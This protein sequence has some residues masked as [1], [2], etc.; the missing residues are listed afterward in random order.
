[1]LGTNVGSTDMVRYAQQEGITVSVA[2]NLGDESGAKSIADRAV[3][4]STADVEGLIEYGREHGVDAV[5]AGVSEFN[6][7]NALSVSEALG[8]KF[9]C[10]SEQWDAFMDKA[11]FRGL[12]EKYGVPTPATYVDGSQRLG[13]DDARNFAP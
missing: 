9:Y 8:T 3:S 5:L 2:D 12:C 10:N 1:M 11:Q 7:R 4:I 13:V 6:L